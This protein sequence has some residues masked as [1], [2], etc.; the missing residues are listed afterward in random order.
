MK[1]QDL[2]TLICCAVP[3][4]IPTP[5]ICK[6]SPQNRTNETPISQEDVAEKTAS[7]CDLE[8]PGD[9]IMWSGRS[10]APG[11]TSVDIHSDYGTTSGNVF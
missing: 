3:P 4:H 2:L 6:P 1:T 9:T 10:S 7:Q 5:H 8:E 11:T